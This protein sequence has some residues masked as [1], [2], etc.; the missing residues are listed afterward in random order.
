MRSAADEVTRSEAGK[1]S[2]VVANTTTSVV[3]ATEQRR[4]SLR[5]MA[6]LCLIRCHNA[7]I[8]THPVQHHT[9]VWTSS[10]V[11]LDDIQIGA[12]SQAIEVKICPA[13]KAEGQAFEHSPLIDIQLIH[14]SVK[15]DVAYAGWLR[16]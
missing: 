11:L 2:T 16:C 10:Q 8:S 13:G 6:G 15:I 1:C 12:V 9:L 4:K 14:D 5:L 3:N 7:R